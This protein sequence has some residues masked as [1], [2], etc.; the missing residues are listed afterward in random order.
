[1]LVDLATEDSHIPHAFTELATHQPAWPGKSS[2]TRPDRTRQDKISCR[3][4][5]SGI[6]FV[7]GVCV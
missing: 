1:M 7:E 6:G 2:L 4:F 5:Y 3:D